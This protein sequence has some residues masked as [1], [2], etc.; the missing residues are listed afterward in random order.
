M[1]TGQSEFN[2]AGAQ[3][4]EGGGGREASL[5]EASVGDGKAV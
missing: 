2:V 5:E 1:S 4:G 3:W